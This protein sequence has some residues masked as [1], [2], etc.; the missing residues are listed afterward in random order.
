MAQILQP[1]PPSPSEPPSEVSQTY[2]NLLRALVIP[3]GTRFEERTIITDRD[4]IVGDRCEIA[5]GLTGR[6]ILCGAHVAIGGDLRAQEELRVDTGSIVRGDAASGKSA[7]LGEFSIVEGRLQ[8]QGDLDLGPEVKVVGGFEARGTI[9]IRN[10][11]PVVFFV[12]LYILTVLRLGRGEDL[13]KLLADMEKE[14]ELQVIDALLVP[15]GSTLSHDTL[16]SPLGIRI[17]PR[18]RLLGNVQATKATV[19]EGSELF[20]SLRARG[21]ITL[22]KGTVLHGNVESKATVFLEEGARVHGS[23]IGKKIRVHPR[24]V[25]KGKLQAAQGVEFIS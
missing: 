2:G 13:E 11:L 20:G 14:E 1:P 8:V 16:R 10:P 22:E 5:Y 19:G 9:Q 3:A 6:S 12:L 17:G 21:N 23:V 18:C 24:A 7:F 25:V 15:P 4:I